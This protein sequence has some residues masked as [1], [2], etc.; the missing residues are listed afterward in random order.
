MF[1]PFFTEIETGGQGKSSSSLEINGIL[2]AFGMLKSFQILR[3][4]KN[5]VKNTGQKLKNTHNQ[6]HI[7]N[8]Y[9]HDLQNKPQ[10]TVRI[11]KIC[12]LISTNCNS[13]KLELRTARA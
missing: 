2:R 8:T 12:L 5:V 11:N 13:L 6:G 1:F 7:K 9:M 10:S 3:Y 4:A